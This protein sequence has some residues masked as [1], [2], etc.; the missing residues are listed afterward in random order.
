MRLKRGTFGLNRAVAKLAQMRPFAC[1]SIYMF[2]LHELPVLYR[3]YEKGS[4]GC[5]AE[6]GDVVTKL[7]CQKGTK[8]FPDSAN[9][10]PLCLDLRPMIGSALCSASLFNIVIRISP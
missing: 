2:I 5:G 8:S 6:D 3:D 4:K 10:N 9:R 1:F 7:K